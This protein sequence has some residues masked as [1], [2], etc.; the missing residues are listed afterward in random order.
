MLRPELVQ[1]SGFQQNILIGNRI[2]KDYFVTK[3]VGESN[4][5]VHAGSY[6][7]ALKSAGIEM[8]NIMTYSSILP[9]IANEIP[10]PQQITH[11]AVMESIMAVANGRKGEH[12]SAGITYGWLW[13]KYTNEK[14]GG[15]VCEHNGVYSE[16]E[17]K[18]LLSESINELYYNG[19]SEQFDI[20]D[21]NVITE[22]LTPEKEYGTALVSLCFTS[23]ICPVLTYPSN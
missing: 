18:R 7:L 3:G 1:A 9:G 6:H 11:G 17:I 12:L 5:T 15:L 8:A 14:Y 23:Y 13:D 20:R 21:I 19:F 4:I 2:P 16:E 10:R 22:T